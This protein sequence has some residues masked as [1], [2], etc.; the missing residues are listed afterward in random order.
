MMD[1][2][3]TGNEVVP[4]PVMATEADLIE[5]RES[6]DKLSA[7]VLDQQA[8]IVLLERKVTWHL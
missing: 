5:L 2:T 7:L 6:V 8:R 1:W 3:W 4:N